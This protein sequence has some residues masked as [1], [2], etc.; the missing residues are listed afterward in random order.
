MRRAKTTFMITLLT[1][2]HPYIEMRRAKTTFMITLLSPI[3]PYIEMRQA[4]TTLTLTLARMVTA[5]RSL[6]TCVVL[7]LDCVTIQ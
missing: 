4:K 6:Y 1:P 5:R 3:H 7:T 2:I